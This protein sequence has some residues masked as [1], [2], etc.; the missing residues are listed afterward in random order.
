MSVRVESVAAGIEK[1][2]PRNYAKGK[3]GL[4]VTDNKQLDVELPERKSS[5]TRSDILGD[6]PT[7]RKSSKEGELTANRKSH[8]RKVHDSE[9]LKKA[10]ETEALRKAKEQ[11][12]EAVKKENDDRVKEEAVKVRKAAEELSERKRSLERVLEK[13]NVVPTPNITTNSS[14]T[15]DLIKSSENKKLLVGKNTS[16]V[17]NERFLDMEEPLPEPPPTPQRSSSPIE[18]SAPLIISTEPMSVSSSSANKSEDK[19]NCSTSFDSLDGSLDSGSGGWPEG[20]DWL[21]SEPH[22]DSV[23]SPGNS[24]TCSRSPPSPPPGATPTRHVMTDWDE[25]MEPN[26]GRKFYYNAKVAPLDCNQTKNSGI[27]Q[28]TIFLGILEITVT[29]QTHEKSWKP[30]RRTARCSTEGNLFNQALGS[31]TKLQFH[32]L[33]QHPR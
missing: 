15:S 10:K 8:E 11:E 4:E 12:R 5:E 14:N 28:M 26:S 1:V 17:T 20:G 30:P 27:H 29:L 6:P 3:N 23:Q 16:H 2:D 25:F 22:R 7:L 18:I 32:E 21:G 9:A 24:S 13:E 19:S 31:L 33:D